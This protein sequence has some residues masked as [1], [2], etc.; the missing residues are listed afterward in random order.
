MGIA[1]MV[2]G[3]ISAILAFIPMC[4]YVAFVPAIIGL[5]LG[6]IDAKKKASKN[7]PKGMSVAGIV[8]NAI[9]IVLIFLWTVVFVSAGTELDGVADEIMEQVEAEVEANQ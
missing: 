4:G 3:I 2:I 5:I 7:L 9:A 1:A 8:L 6:I